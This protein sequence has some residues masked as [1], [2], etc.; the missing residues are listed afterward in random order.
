MV[1]SYST[2]HFIYILLYHTVAGR[3]YYSPDNSP[4]EASPGGLARPLES[5]GRGSSKER[6]C[7]DNSF[8]KDMMSQI[9]CNSSLFKLQSMSSC[10]AVYITFKKGLK[11]HCR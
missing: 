5:I 4:D 11:I 3:V 10:S 8:S 6:L 7:V 1:C 9:G 2:A